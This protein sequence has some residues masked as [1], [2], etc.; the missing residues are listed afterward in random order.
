[1]RLVARQK[2]LA[3]KCVLMAQFQSLFT[4]TFI[5]RAEMLLDLVDRACAVV[6]DGD[7]AARGIVCVLA[8]LRAERG[9]AQGIFRLFRLVCKAPVCRND[10]KKSVRFPV[11]PICG[12]V[13]R[14][15]SAVPPDRPLLHPA[16]RLPDLLARRDV[17]TGVDDL[18]GLRTHRLRDRRRLLI[19][20]P[21]ECEKGGEH[22]RCAD[23]QYDPQ[24]RDRKRPSKIA[25]HPILP[26]IGP[27]NCP[28]FWSSVNNEAGAY[29]CTRRNRCCR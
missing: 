1:M 29:G 25:R 23:G 12:P 4:A 11:Q 5:E 18:A 27:G 3:G 22:D 13:R 21:P 9:L 28:G 24:A 17:V 14:E 2:C 20:V 26:N 16:D 10:R 7:D 15:V 19:Y 8:H 6:A